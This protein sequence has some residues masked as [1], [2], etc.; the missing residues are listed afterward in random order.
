[1][2]KTW[3]HVGLVLLAT[4][5]GGSIA[6][7]A[8]E[9]RWS[10]R[11]ANAA[12]ERWPDGRFAPAGAKWTWNY[13]LGTLLRGIDSVWFSTADGRYFKYIKASVDQF[14]NADGTIPTYNAEENQLA[15]A[16]AALRSYPRCA[17]CEGCDGALS[18]A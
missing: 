9:Q 6:A 7:N 16:S 14:V 13:E 2:K 11:T 5:A 1:M 18:A 4:M 12:M 8:Q 3:I 17:V 10:V 15:A